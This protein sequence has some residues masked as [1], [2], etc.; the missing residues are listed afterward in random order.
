ME[1]GIQEVRYI[2]S[3]RIDWML[4]LKN[5]L[6][7]YLSPLTQGPFAG[8]AKM[9]MFK[10]TVDKINMM[11]SKASRMPFLFLSSGLGVSKS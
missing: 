2:Q 11:T 4:K 3:R 9:A 8:G 10:A 5:I 6:F 7:V 1:G